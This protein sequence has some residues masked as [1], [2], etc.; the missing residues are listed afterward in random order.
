MAL[1]LRL[2]PYSIR[3]ISI[4]FL[5]SW[6]RGKTALSD[7]KGK[8]KEKKSRQR[9]MSK[10]PAVAF[11]FHILQKER[12]ES[13]KEKDAFLPLSSF[14][15]HSPHL[16]VFPLLSAVSFSLSPSVLSFLLAGCNSFS[17][18]PPPSFPSPSFLP[19]LLKSMG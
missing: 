13:R 18:L 15:S 14:S 11:S 6:S 7:C 17:P 10:N 4:P 19:L 16:R 2:S 1:K 9:K 5:L 8:G 3:F 12:K